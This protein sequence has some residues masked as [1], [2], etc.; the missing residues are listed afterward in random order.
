VKNPKR[1]AVIVIHPSMH[2]PFRSRSFKSFGRSAPVEGPSHSGTLA[3]I[4]QQSKEPTT[5]STWNRLPEVP[6]AKPL[7]GASLVHAPESRLPFVESAIGKLPEELII[8][9]ITHA[10]TDALS[11]A[12]LSSICS[13]L[14]NIVISETR[15]WANIHVIEQTHK[16]HEWMNRTYEWPH[17]TH[18]WVQLCLSRAGTASHIAMHATLNS[19]RAY[20]ALR[21]VSK[22][23]EMLDIRV[24]A[25]GGHGLN[26]HDYPFRLVCEMDMHPPLLRILRLRG[27]VITPRGD[28]M[29]EADEV[30]RLMSHLIGP[31]LITTSKHTPCLARLIIYGGIVPEN[32][33]A[34]P[35]LAH[36]ELNLATISAQALYKML[37]G[38]LKL[39]SLH[40]ES[41][42]AV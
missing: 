16:T 9:I 2:W 18:E 8:Q 33:P 35:E 23:V 25:S 14:R 32:L 3:D 38:C 6:G 37:R 29:R 13:A 39:R 27:S 26:Y 17:R 11:L 24:P 40:Q 34:L 21:D 31:E 41:P 5:P 4:S 10:V 28:N 30:K 36:L 12:Q 7:N 15:L 20:E 1:I 19:V 42:K 22:R